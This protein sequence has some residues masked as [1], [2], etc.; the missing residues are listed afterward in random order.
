MDGS[1]SVTLPFDAI[2]VRAERVRLFEMPLLHGKLDDADVGKCVPARGAEHEQCA[3]R[4]AFGRQFIISIW[5]W[6]TGFRAI[7]ADGNPQVIEQ[8]VCTERCDLA[9]FPGVVR[10]GARP[11]RGSRERV[12]IAMNIYATG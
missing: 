10:H 8:R 9:M 2:R 7:G 3:S 1:G 5:A 6:P 11:H 4:C 12:S